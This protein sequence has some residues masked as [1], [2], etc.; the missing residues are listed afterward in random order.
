MSRT[1]IEIKTAD[2]WTMKGIPIYDEAAVGR[3]WREMLALFEQTF[4]AA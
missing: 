2:G 1:A 3:H 4:K